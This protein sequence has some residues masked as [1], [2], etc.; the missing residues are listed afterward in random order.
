M[1]DLHNDYPTALPQERFDEYIRSCG[2]NDV[3]A[4]IWTSEL[5]N[6]E[7]VVNR[8]TSSLCAISKVK[9]V[10]I[11]DVGFLS[12]S[13]AEAFPFERYVYCSLGWNY[14]NAFVGGALDDGALTVEGKR[15]IK[16]M[17]GKCAVDLAHTNEKS[18]YGILDVAARILCSHTGFNGHLRSIDDRRI[19][20]IVDRSGIIGLS[21]VKTFT[22]AHS[23][24]ELAV[25]IDRF[26]SKYGV[27]NLALGT[28]FNGS[29]D[30]SDDFKSYD[31][32]PTLYGELARLGY[33]SS[34]IEKIFTT[35]AKRFYEETEHERHL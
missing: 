20:A 16:A 31:D 23:A 22:D 3:T 28:D 35:N 10:A 32:M 33:V 21:A 1:I 9:Y 29:T 13:D 11:E 4:V 6:A 34:D 18:F 12:D 24:K 14:N 25:V 5:A 8:L 7:S 19:R 17:N 26:A 2:E 30:I 15:L 27:D